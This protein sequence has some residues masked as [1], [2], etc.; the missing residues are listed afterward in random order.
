MLILEGWEG[1][2]WGPEGSPST[3]RPFL[4]GS[5]EGGPGVNYKKDLFGKMEGGGRGLWGPYKKSPFWEEEG[6]RPEGPPAKNTYF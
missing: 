1:K 4:R 6:E 5:Q 3:K 2:A